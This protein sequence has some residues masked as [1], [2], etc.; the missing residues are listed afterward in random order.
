MYGIPPLQKFLALT[1][2]NLDTK[3]GLDIAFALSYYSRM[4]LL[5]NLLP[6]LRESANP[7]ILS[8]LNAGQEE[9]MIENDIGLENPQ[10]FGPRIAI[11]H[12]TTMMTLALEHL[13][14]N[15]KRIT[16]IHSFPGLVATDIFSRLKAPES[17]GIIGRI[18]V[19]VVG[20]FVGTLQWLF[21]MST[22]DSGARQAFILTNAEFG[23]GEA[24]RIDDKCE[25]TVK[26]GV[27]EQYRELGWR[28]KVWEYTMGVFDK[29]PVVNS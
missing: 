18:L 15:D 17:F 16:F 19:K 2:H 9:K 28:E 21:G 8:V 29:I 22:A 4:R 5:I 1:Y 12:T 10:N 25:P 23:P 3:E 27:L 6:L 7:R 14:L 26:A 13:A 20:R 11:V 24:W